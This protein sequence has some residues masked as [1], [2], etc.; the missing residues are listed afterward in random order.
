MTV[1][2]PIKKVE[3][4]M[5]PPQYMTSLASYLF[6]WC[7]ILVTSECMYIPTS[8][9]AAWRAC[10]LKISLPWYNQQ[11]FGRSMVSHH[12]N[13]FNNY[14]NYLYFMS[15]HHILCIQNNCLPFFIVFLETL[16]Y[17]NVLS[18][19]NQ[20]WSVCKIGKRD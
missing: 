14:K 18:F 1:L 17:P 20:V 12:S 19:S 16:S 10:L 2:F 5:V 9:L 13:V 3:T 11:N 4:C 6:I 8:C 15:I 7:I